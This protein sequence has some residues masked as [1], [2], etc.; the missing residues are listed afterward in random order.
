MFFERSFLGKKIW[1]QNRQKC[2]GT[3]HFWTKI[4]KKELLKLLKL[5]KVSKFP[6]GTFS[7]PK[8]EKTC[9]TWK[10]LHF[11]KNV[12]LP[13]RAVLLPNKG[14]NME[15]HFSSFKIGWKWISLGSLR[16]SPTF[17]QI[18]AS[19]MTFC[20]FL[21]IFYYALPVWLFPVFWL[22]HT[23]FSIL[24]WLFANF[25]HLLCLFMNI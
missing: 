25:R 5:C 17:F 23:R 22:L 18:G 9:A 13:F 7:P 4:S 19:S 12:F 11:P 8:N 1:T 14:H 21:A 20:H 24:A 6:N 2:W 10:A 16:S 15:E 3:E